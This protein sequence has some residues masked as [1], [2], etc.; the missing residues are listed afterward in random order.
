MKQSWQTPP[1]S[2]L[3]GASSRL[4]SSSAILTLALA[5]RYLPSRWIDPVLVKALRMIITHSPYTFGYSAVVSRRL[6]L[7]NSTPS[8]TSQIAYR[9]LLS[10][11]EA[12][13][14]SRESSALESNWRPEVNKGFR[15]RKAQQSPPSVW[16]KPH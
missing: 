13:A 15:K 9:A 1:R 14:L 12:V 10:Q 6:Y 2:S 11:R 3:L 7:P 8:K 5:D 16:Q 4:I